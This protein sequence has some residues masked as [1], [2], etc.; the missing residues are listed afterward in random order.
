MIVQK[1]NISLESF[2]NR[3]TRI[4]QFPH[5]GDVRVIL[6]L[7]MNAKAIMS[8]MQYRR[9]RTYQPVMES[10][11][12]R[13]VASMIPVGRI[14]ELPHPVRIA[15]KGNM[16]R[17]VAAPDAKLGNVAVVVSAQIDTLNPEWSMHFLFSLFRPS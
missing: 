9:M 17:I 10:L 11:R 14:R 8:R 6:V 4:R 13:E 2:R 12:P 16:T 7:R 3:N 15:P 1:T 5:A